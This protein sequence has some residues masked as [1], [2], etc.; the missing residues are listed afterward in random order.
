M[1]TSVGP[2]TFGEENLVFGYDTGDMV[3]SFPGIPAVNC[4]RV[5]TTSGNGNS[6]GNWSVT[7]ITDGSI[8]PPRKGARV[9]KF[10]A[11]T[12]SNLYRQSG[13]YYGGGFANDNTGNS[14]ILGRTSPSNFTTV[15]EPNKYRWGFWVR[16][17]ASNNAGWNFSIDIGD[18]NIVSYTVGNNTDWYFI[19]TVNTD[20][21]N[22]NNYPYDFFDIFT[23]NQGLTLYI[24]DMGIMRSPGTVDSLPILQAYPQ[25]VDYGQERTYTEG[26]KDLT[27]NST[28]DLTNVSFD[29]D[30]QMTFD[31][32]NDYV[33]I[34]PR[35]QYTIAEPWT[36]EL[37][38]K[39]TT[40][41]TS[42]NGL[43]GGTL[44]NG[45]YWMFHSAGNLTYYEGYSGEVGTK[46]TYRTWTF[47]NTFTQNQFHHLTIAYSPNTATNGTF[48][49]YYNGGEK[50]D[51]FSFTFTWSHSLDMQFIGAGDG[52][53][54]TNDIH[55][56]KQYNRALTASEIKANYNA[57]KGRFNI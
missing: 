9:F 1:P 30:A 44:Q 27:G 49:L 29:S 18:R 28:I 19:S 42:W 6:K 17:V 51:S 13:Y 37:V 55:Y 22:A 38:F 23:S 21:T 50:V 32:S 54:G 47:A 57:I 20:G 5:P 45:G 24:A 3:N 2:N 8:T 12:T 43:F 36:T 53:F 56:F 10:V 46:I 31:G 33:G 25:W 4:A 35:R 15:S 41:T 40:T 26:L 14:L 39:P 7:E 52:R 11:G 34:S 16:G 48:T